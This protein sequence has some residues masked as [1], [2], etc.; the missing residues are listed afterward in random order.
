MIRITR[1]DSSKADGNLLKIED[2]IKAVKESLANLVEYAIEYFRNLKKNFGE[3]KE[4]KTEIKTFENISASKVIIANKK[5]FVDYDEGFIGYGLRKLQ[6]VSDCSE[7]DDIICFF[8]T[9]K[10]L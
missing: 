7:I 5:L 2:Q 4:R 3:G 9:G 10:M 6:A 8:K 1:F